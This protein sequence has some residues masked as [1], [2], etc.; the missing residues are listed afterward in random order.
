MFDNQF[1]TVYLYINKEP[2]NYSGSSCISFTF[3]NDLI[4]QIKHIN[5]TETIEFITRE[6]AI[7][8]LKH[9]KNISIDFH[10]N[11]YK[12]NING[13]TNYYINYEPQHDRYV[14]TGLYKQYPQFTLE[15]LCKTIINEDQGESYD[16]HNPEMVLNELLN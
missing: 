1:N 12:S 14:I 13:L 4:K 11:S 16:C 6:S 5:D 2:I 9:D 15:M 8:K 3:G 10:N 7:L